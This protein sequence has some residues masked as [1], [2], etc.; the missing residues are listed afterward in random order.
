M[1]DPIGAD[2][3]AADSAFASAGATAVQKATPSGPD[4]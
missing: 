2:Q 4:P 3:M 1:S